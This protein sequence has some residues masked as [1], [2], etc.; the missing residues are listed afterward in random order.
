MRNDRASDAS[1]AGRAT[2]LGTATSVGVPVVGCRCPVCTSADPRDKRLRCSCLVEVNGLSVLIDTAPDFRAQALRAG[3]EQVDAVLY[4]HHHFDH[5][6]G[7]DDLR[8][9][10]FYNR[11]PIPCYAHPGTADVF[12]RKYEYIFG[13]HPHPSAPSLEMHEVSGPFTVTGR[14]DA[15]AAA[16]VAVV[17]LPAWHG[18][19]E[20]LGFRIG[21]FAYLTDI[22][23]LPEETLAR[24]TGVEEL[25]LN[26]LRFEP[27]PAH[28][29]VP[30]AVQVARRVGA[31]Q[32]S[33][34]HMTH[35][36]LHARDDGSLPDGVRL[37]YDGLTVPIAS[38]VIPR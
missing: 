8:P 11:R 25:V 15:N 3:I 23:Y 2:L 35:D 21:S 10:L 6:A 5:I 30:E 26:A 22:S 27:H 32:T 24:L 19:L 4:T 1:P 14:Y 20:I 29:S 38:V 7:I 12:R 36:V 17:P 28:L 33:L 13:N 9:Y 18:A 34:I 31:R 16:D 37:A